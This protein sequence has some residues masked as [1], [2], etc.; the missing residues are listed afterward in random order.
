MSDANKYINAYV[1]HAVG[2]LHE[3][4]N[5]ILQLKTQLKLATDLNSEKDSLIG[6]LGQELETAKQDNDIIRKLNDDIKLLQDTNDRLAKEQNHL[7][8]ALNQ[9]AE[10]KRMINDR[11]TK[12]AELESKISKKA[13]NSKKKNPVPVEPKLEPEKKLGKNDDF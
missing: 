13:I 12:I 2:M 9:I 8:T 10:M 1:D 11:D 5:L 7:H 3:N 4:V 6:R